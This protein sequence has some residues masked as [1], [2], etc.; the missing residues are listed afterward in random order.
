MRRWAG[1]ALVAASL[2][3][4]APPA[5]ALPVPIHVDAQP[6]AEWREGAKPGP[7]DNFTYAGGLVLTSKDTARLHGLSDLVVLP[8]GRMISQSDE[9]DLVRARIV[10]DAEGRLTGVA[11]AT[12]AR[13]AGPDGQPLPAGKSESDAE[14]LALWPNGDLMVSFE[15]HHRIL[16]YPADGTPPREVPHP[17]APFPNNEGMEALALDPADGPDAYRVGREDTRET[18]VCR[19]AGGC[20]KSFAVPGAG[21]GWLTSARALPGGRWAFLLRD[22]NP[23]TEAVTIRI[24]IT[25]AAGR[26]LDTH[27][28]GAPATVDNFEGLAALPN[29]DGSVRLYLISDDNFSSR[30]RTLLLAFDWRPPPGASP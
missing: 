21:E 29:P 5:S 22:Y 14:G 16:L 8:D 12:F 9:G 15:R 25:D 2:A 20:A 23:L 7:A 6:V 18:W 30:Q 24:R 4:C 17:D 19:L 13:L 11:D 3:A 26:T 28:I 27:R 1:L 10:L